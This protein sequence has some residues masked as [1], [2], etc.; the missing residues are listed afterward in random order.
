MV[1][2]AE[3]EAPLPGE[4]GAPD[5]GLTPLFAAPEFEEDASPGQGGLAM[6]ARPA[7]R[8]ENRE[9]LPRRRDDGRGVPAGGDVV[10]GDPPE[11]VPHRA[12]VGAVGREGA[13]AGRRR[14]GGGRPGA[15]DERAAE[16]RALEHVH[17]AERLVRAGHRGQVGPVGVGVG[18]EGA[19]VLGEQGRPGG[20]AASRRRRRRRGAGRPRRRGPASAAAQKP[21]S[22]SRTST[23]RD[24]RSRVHQVERA[25]DVLV[26][27][28][29]PGAQHRRTSDRPVTGDHPSQHEPYPV[30]RA[31]AGGL[32]A[33]RA[34]AAGPRRRR[35]RGR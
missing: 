34:A 29:R 14:A 3:D 9:R 10:A 19:Q 1:R 18:V 21:C 8:G 28:R 13:H 17:A 24:G 4:G 12:G 5:D 31:E 25:L 22:R 2:A 15:V 6:P 20:G 11:R 27:G 33:R 16:R 35:G 32:A 7:P 23:S 30:G 26:L